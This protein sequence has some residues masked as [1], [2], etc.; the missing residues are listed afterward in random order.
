M[1]DN[2]AEVKEK[3]AVIKKVEA[4]INEDRVFKDLSALQLSRFQVLDEILKELLPSTELE[5]AVTILN[6]AIADI[7]SAPG[8]RYLLGMIDLEKAGEDLKGYLKSLLDDCNRNT[9]W[10]VVEHICDKILEKDPEN[11]IAL[12]SKVSSV[13]QLRGKKETR[14]FLKKL[15]AV[16]HN[17][18]DIQKSYALSILEEETDEAIDLLKK[19]IESYA[20][21]KNYRSVDEIWNILVA[22]DY[23]DIPFFEKLERIIVGN[24]EK[25][26]MAAYL[27]GLLDP[28][29]QIE[30]W[31]V[32]VSILKKI[33]EYE[34]AS[35]KARSELVRAYRIM[36][37][38]HSLLDEFLKLSEL[39]NHKKSPGPC[40]DQFERNIVFDKDNYVYHRTRGVGKVKLID[41]EQMIVDFRENPDQR[42]SIQ[43][44]IS[45]LRPLGPGHI[46]VKLYESPDDVHELFENEVS[47]FFELLLTSFGKKMVLSEIKQEIVG[48]FLELPEWSRWWSRTRAQLKKDPKFGFNPRK[49]D[50]LI[51]RENPISMSDE[52]SL[53]FQSMTDW[54]KK[55][56]V[57][58]Q[59]LKEQDAHNAIQSCIQFYRENESNKEPI[60][61]LHCYLYLEFAEKIIADEIPD[62]ML[63]YELIEEQFKNAETETLINYCKST[64]QIEMKK[65]IVNLIVAT[66]DDYAGILGEIAFEVPI[67]INKYVIS[68]LESKQQTDTLEEFFEAALSKYRDY[69]DIFLWCAKNVLTDT[70][71]QEWIK[72]SKQDVMLRVFRLLKPLVSIEK[73]GT[74]L[75]NSAIDIIFASNDQTVEGIKT[76]ELLVEIIK[77]SNLTTLRRMNALFR[78]VPYVSDAHKE[79]FYTFVQELRSDFSMDSTMGDPDAVAAEAEIL[80]PEGNEILITADALKQRTEYYDNLV[81]V[82]MPAN[83]KDIGEAQEKGDLRE[84]A[85]YKAAMEKQNQLRAEITKISKELKH[86]KA[87]DL[88]SVKTDIVRI[89][90]TVKLDS[91]DGTI[92]YTILGPWDADTDKSIISYESPLGNALIGTAVNESIKLGNGQVFTVK[93]ISSYK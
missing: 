44:A 43:M 45:S 3:S 28:H 90:T 75:K 67:K 50:E 82:E 72:H 2:K 22:R 36:Y 25:T 58:L 39:T 37:A 83:S 78:D 10:T 59:A 91:P 62:R 15:V 18:P 38:D 73:K 74:K 84:N 87:I 77:N 56:D 11:R 53:K 64:S 71:Q 17:N 68:E 92:T 8:C 27:M 65:E 23:E 61:Q 29:R 55:L 4:Q 79:N 46:W 35:S 49:K 86:A 7:A 34:P 32:V 24:R 41:N 60:K 31:P 85:E 66:R 1:S 20:R 93:A 70:W 33:L 52:L 13:E 89:G 51:L 16:D 14:P 54:E 12:R 6:E 80:L 26:R 47:L 69:P 63:K 48:T 81:N 76:N 40:I 57:A 19:A 42:M 88:G 21:A 5:D 30:N 9:R